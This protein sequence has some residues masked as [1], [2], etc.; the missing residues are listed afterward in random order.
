MSV[1]SVSDPA[2]GRF[3]SSLR[4]NRLHLRRDRGLCLVTEYRGVVASHRAHVFDATFRTLATLPLTGTP[5]R[6]RVSDDGRYGAITVF[7]R[8]HS[9][10]E[11]GFSTKTTIIDVRAGVELG[12]LEQFQVWRDGHVFRAVDF[13]FWGVTFMQNSTR[14]YA[15]LASAGTPY[16][17]E[18]DIATR[19]IRVLRPGIECGS[20]SP[21]YRRLAYK[22]LVSGT[23]W[24]VHVLDLMTNEDLALGMEGRSVDD[25]VEW[26]DD[27]HVLY[28]AGG[29]VGTA[30]W[31][32][33][34]DGTRPPEI[35]IPFAYSPSVL[36]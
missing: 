17:V 33:R 3:V 29:N 31:K 27:D 5:S 4:C 32:L 6:T 14:F 8:G 11:L 26:L 2:G 16:L 28:H 7:E 23:T 19:T 35:L 13:N 36:R 22:Q 9:Y 34:A 12:D 18:G 20:L 24:R 25:Q 10:A 30:V 21:D 1:V 15:T